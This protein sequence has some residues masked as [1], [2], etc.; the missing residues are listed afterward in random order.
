MT[1]PLDIWDE[2]RA[3]SRPGVEPAGKDGLWL[4]DLGGGICKAVDDRDTLFLLIEIPKFTR[5]PDTHSRQLSAV[6]GPVTDDKDGDE[7]H[8]LRLWVEDGDF[9]KVFR[10]FAAQVIDEL[11]GVAE[12]DRVQRLEGLLVHWRRFWSPPSSFDEIGLF[13]ELRFMKYWLTDRGAAVDAWGGGDPGATLK[14]FQLANRDVEVK[15]TKREGSARHVVHGLDQLASNGSRPLDLFSCRIRQNPGGRTVSDLVAEVESDI[16]GDQVRIDGF[17]AGLARYGFW[18]GKPG[19]E[20]F[21]VVD[22][23]LYRVE[24]DFPRLTRESL[25]GDLPRSIPDNTVRYELNLDGCGEWLVTDPPP[26]S[27]VESDS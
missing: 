5:D 10:S 21:E 22:E 15:T 13:G 26:H 20:N 12:K 27:G 23:R 18:P 11:N 8:M 2:L 19:L 14:D 24:G 9:E 7:R 4:R 17:M 16:A 6:C 1:E 3:K 25:K